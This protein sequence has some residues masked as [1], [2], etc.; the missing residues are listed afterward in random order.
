MCRYLLWIFGLA[1]LCALAL[2]LIGTFGL[3]GSERGS[4]AGIYLVPLGVPWIWLVDLAPRSLQPWL[5]AAAPS[6]NLVV[7]WTLCRTFGAGQ[8]P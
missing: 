4:L 5:A 7:L 1:Y 2:L 6:L 3:F 8:R